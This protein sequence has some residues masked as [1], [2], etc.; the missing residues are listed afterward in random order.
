VRIFISTFGTRGDIQPFVALAK[1]LAAVGH[2]VTICTAEG[3]KQFIQEHGLNYSH[4]NNTMLELVYEVV[5]GKR[6]LV[7]LIKPMLCAMRQSLN[8]EFAAAQ[9]FSPD[10]IIYHPKA[11][12]SY[13][14]A[15][16]LRIPAILSLPLPFYTPTSAFPNPF[17]SRLNFGPLF[18]RLTYKFARLSSALF[19]RM[20]NRFRAEVLGLPPRRLFADLLVDA[21][22]RQVPVLYPYS[23]HVLPIP[24]DFPEHVHVTG[25]WFLDHSTDWHPPADL[26]HFLESGSAPIYVGFG[27]MGD[28]RSVERTQMV[29]GAVS[30]A[31][32]RAVIATGWGG[33]SANE[34]IP[35]AYVASDIPHDWLFPRMAAVI[36]H[37]GAG[38]TAAGLRAGK[39]TIICPFL[40]DQPFWGEVVYKGGF[41]P[42]PI[43]KKH[44]SAT[45]LAAAITEATQSG[46]IRE[47]AEEVGRKIRSEDGIARAVEIISSFRQLPI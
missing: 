47:K 35:D 26:V 18:N 21:S 30:I 25:Y 31:R 45:R 38:T 9:A 40:G 16:K 4:M 13:H 19:T 2:V 6:T 34:I 44:L 12:G 36:H 3:F 22:A 7:R 27:S 33:I 8:D 32:K 20:T 46:S 11:L 29:L 41:G 37:G 14:I 5:E 39:P 24:E 42:R 28:S 10:L 1:G 17:F 15:E 23:K 43:Q